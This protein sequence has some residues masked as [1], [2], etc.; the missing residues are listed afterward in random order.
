VRTEAPASRSGR[1]G[2]RAEQIFHEDL[3]QVHI[4]TGRVFFWLFLAQWLF[5]IILALII[6]PY[7]WSGRVRTLNSHVELAFIGGAILNALPIALLVLRPGRAGTRHIVAITQMLWSAMFIHLSGGRIETHFHVFVSLA[8]LSFYRDPRLLLTATLVVCVDHLMRGF[9]WPESVY[10][11]ANPEWWRFLEHAAWVVFE[12]IILY[13]GCQ[14]GLREMKTLSDREATLELAKQDVEKEVAER[15][16]EL[17]ASGDRNRMLIEN[18]SAVPWELDRDSC[19][20]IY[21]A[22]QMKDVFAVAPARTSLNRIFPDL[23]HAD[24]R[25]AFRY[26][27]QRAAEGDAG[28]EMYIDSR[29][30]TQANEI[31]HMRSFVASQRDRASAQS[32]C[33]I[34]LDVTQQK[35]LAIELLQAQKLESVGRLAAGV[36]HE[37]N[38]PVQFVA[39]NVEFL[40]TSMTDVVGVI[41]A[42]RDLRQAVQSTGDIAAA[43][44]RADEADK[45]AELDFILLNAPL[46][47][48][49]SIEGLGRIATIVRSMKEFAHPDQA[50]KTFADVNQAIR[51]TLVIAHNE[52]KYVAEIDTQFSDLPPVPCYLGEINQVILN[53]IVNASH[54]ISDVVKDTGS[55]G[56]LTI[57]TRLD[58]DGVEISISDTGTGIP[59]AA[60]GKIF[61]PFF[62]TKPV[63][64]GT[65]QG[66]AI[67]HSVIVKKHGGS[68]R[69]ETERGTGTTFFI[70]LPVGNSSE[71]F[72][73]DEV[74]A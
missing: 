46:A 1:A 6:S 17:R 42:Y 10:G 9:L 21:L 3:L 22:P 19:R 70:R 30:M 36:A 29:V 13:L 14:R 62:T 50:E 65:G 51:S 39:D 56:K 41:H 60:R 45:A 64:K 59:E 52:Y 53:L 55:F 4:K 26:F 24:D 35:K 74:A 49:S 63:G 73:V 23:L 48:D 69:F 31:L 66:L 20:I 8:F 54:A 68:L 7:A 12:D 61:D 43:A 72:D 47:I 5:A 11:I 27:I 71:S 25:E 2:A 33:G 44:R 67:A 32:V 34:S 58:G 15:T 18:T 57:R 37:I 38:T 28:S 16:E 40:R